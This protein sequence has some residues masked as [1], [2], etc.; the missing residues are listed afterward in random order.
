MTKGKPWTV[1]DEATLKAMVE[2]NASIDAIA[3]KLNKK[4]DAIYVN[5]FAWD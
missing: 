3:V 1:D 2:T 4:P 5:V